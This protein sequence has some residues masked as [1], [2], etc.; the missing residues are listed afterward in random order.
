MI[1]LTRPYFT[2]DEL[3]E[4]KSVLKSAWVARGPKCT[5][6]EDSVKKFTGAQYAVAVSNCTAALHLALKSLGITDG[7]EV[8]VADFSY[9]ATGF[10]VIYT[11][12]YPVFCDVESTTYNINPLNIEDLIT[13]NTKAIIPVHTFGNPCKMDDILKIAK[14]YGLFVIE[15]AACALGTKYRNKFVGTFGDVGCYS[16]HARK[17]V[18]TGEGGMVVTDSKYIYDYVRRM[19]MFGVESAYNRNERPV[20][21]QVGYNYKMSDISAAVGVA[22]TRKLPEIIKKKQRL[23]EIYEN[24]FEDSRIITP[25]TTTFFGEHTYQSFVGTMS[26]RD[27]LIA[28]LAKHGIEAGI[29]TYAQH[30]QPVF[31]SPEKCTVSERLF[32]RSISLPMYYEMAEE[33]VH[34]V[35]NTV[36]KCL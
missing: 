7:D 11:G 14:H 29:G 4:I 9:P 28:R 19:S 33:D 8:I 6:L 30:C 27:L 26:D 17:G 34:T 25:Q 21:K 36:V 1:P 3:N 13:N 22:Q 20:F 18:T 24:L 2:E 12:A 23:A 5:E 16:F 32:R 10:S 31:N 15:D 35:Y